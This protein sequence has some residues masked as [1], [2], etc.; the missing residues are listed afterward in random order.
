MKI[1]VGY[2]TTESNEHI[3]TKNDITRYNI[4]F[5]DECV[6]QCLVDDVLAE[7]G[8]EAIPAI[9]ANAGASGVIKRNAFDYIESA[10]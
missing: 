1:M 9:Y 4:F 7:E 3:P 6:R 8:V 5:G 10:L 2:F